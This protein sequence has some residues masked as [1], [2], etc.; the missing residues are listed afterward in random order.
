MEEV[1]NIN[2]TNI[3]PVTPSKIPIGIFRVE[4]EK[5]PVSS[6]LE[7]I[8]ENGG[9]DSNLNNRCSSPTPISKIPLR[10]WRNETTAYKNLIEK[11]EKKEFENSFEKNKRPICKINNHREVNS[12][13]DFLSNDLH[14]S[15]TQSNSGKFM[16]PKITINGYAYARTGRQGSKV[17]SMVT[18]QRSR[19][20]DPSRNGIRP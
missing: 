18:K 1:K 5:D 12:N 11:N 3:R 20:E 10:D 8:S 14:E 4:A 16:K 2:E 13:E 9:I 19:S 6:I 17:P 15:G 7:G